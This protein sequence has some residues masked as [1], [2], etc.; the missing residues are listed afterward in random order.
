MNMTSPY[1]VQTEDTRRAYSDDSRCCE[2]AQFE[3]VED[4]MRFASLV[5]A[6]TPDE[7]QVNILRNGVVV[8]VDGAVK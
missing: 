1:C 5:W 2:I 8:H 7:V 6:R 4:A 3:F